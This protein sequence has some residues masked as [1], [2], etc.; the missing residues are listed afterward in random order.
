MC[1]AKFSSLWHPTCRL[2]GMGTRNIAASLLAL[3][4][5]LSTMAWAGSTPQPVRKTLD[6]TTEIQG[7]P[8][9][10]GYAWFYDTGRLERCTVAGNTI[11]GEAQV[12]AGSII[13]LGPEGKPKYV[14][15][16]GRAS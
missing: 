15:Q 6:Q 3:M 13:V 9:A 7:Y 10:K 4:G 8:C 14:F 12:P 1:N 2:L 16:I 11:F 5:L